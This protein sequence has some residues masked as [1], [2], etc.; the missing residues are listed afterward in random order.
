MKLYHKCANNE[1]IK[2]VD[3]TSLYPYVQKYCEYPLG[4]PKI[5]TENFS[6]I[7]EYFGIIK[8]SILPPRGLYLPVLP[9]KINN[10]LI[11]TLCSKCA[12]S[13]QKICDHSN[14]E[15]VLSG[16]W[17]KLEVQKALKCGYQ[18]IKIFEVRHWEKKSKYNK[19]TKSG[20]LFT[21]YIDMFLKLKQEASGYPEECVTE[22]DKNEYTKNY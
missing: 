3:F 11:F 4:H 19:D 22:N 1:K 13:Q 5:I 15:R 2:Y 21:E 7:E 20:G 12:E 6:K 10:K 9:S 17:V 16:T 8:C 14:K 18:I